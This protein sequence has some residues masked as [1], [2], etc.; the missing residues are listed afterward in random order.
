MDLDRVEDILF[1]IENNLKELE[2]QARKAQ[3]Y[4]KL[5]ADYKANSI[6]LAVI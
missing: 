2:K 4:Q 1:E 6:D 3:R 5:K